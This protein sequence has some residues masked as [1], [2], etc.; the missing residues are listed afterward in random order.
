MIAYEIALWVVPVG[1][2][3]TTLLVGARGLVFCWK[4]ITGKDLDAPS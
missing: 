3:L 4:V 2:A 1:V